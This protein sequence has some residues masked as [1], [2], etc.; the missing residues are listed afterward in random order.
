M[1]IRLSVRAEAE[2]EAAPAS[3]LNCRLDNDCGG[4]VKG[5]ATTGAG[6]TC[7]KLRRDWRNSSGGGGTGGPGYP[8]GPPSFGV[9]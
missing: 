6:S 9:L 7:A 3:E 1:A 4:G 5:A 2:V 8:W